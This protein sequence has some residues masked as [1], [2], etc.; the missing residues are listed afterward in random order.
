[1]TA[2]MDAAQ[3]ALRE[4][5]EQWIKALAPELAQRRGISIDPARTC[6][7]QATEHCR[8]SGDFLLLTEDD[9]TVSVWRSSR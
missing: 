5:R 3:P 9:E 6:L 7:S 4:A 2:A 1:M 8:L